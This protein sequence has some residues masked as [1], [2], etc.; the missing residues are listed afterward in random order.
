M[1]ARV[2]RVVI[3][4]GKMEEF[5]AHIDAMLPI[6]RRHPGFGGLL[7]MR[8]GPGDRLEVTV[9]SMWTTLETL[10]DSEDPEYRE[11]LVKFLA[12]CE[13]RPSM[14]EEEVIMSEFASGDP[15]DTITKF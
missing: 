12:L 14:R 8:S 10:Q 5:L 7:A 2:W 15:D 11:A 6:L 3:L 13:H 4:P 1:Y 9:V